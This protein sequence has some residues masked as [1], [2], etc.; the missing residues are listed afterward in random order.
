MSST[1]L[2]TLLVPLF[3]AATA[4]AGEPVV[5]TLVVS[6]ADGA[7]AP[8]LAVKWELAADSLVLHLAA[9]VDPV[10]V[11]R[12]LGSAMP[13]VPVKNAGGALVLSSA[14]PKALLG[15]LAAL[16][17]KTDWEALPDL[18]QLGE[19]GSR[20]TATPEVGGSI[21]AKTSV[22]TSP[23]RRVDGPRR[24]ALREARERAEGEIVSV[25]RGAFPFV[26]LRVKI[27]RPPQAGA[28][29]NQLTRGAIVTAPVALS[30]TPSGVDFA[31]AQTQRNLAAWFLVA[32]DHVSVGVSTAGAGYEIDFLER[33]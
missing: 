9:G 28:L 23:W 30:T 20:S 31:D 15:S 18:T 4:R 12:Q 24:V 3:V 10:S 29:K 25:E 21:R 32:G 6:Q 2:R 27:Q 8:G 14:D 5:D 7:F 33:P 16:H 19:T 26:T 17:L 1:F 13:G 22:P 11:A